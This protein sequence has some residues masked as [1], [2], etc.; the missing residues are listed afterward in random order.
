MHS[1]GYI[2]RDIKP[3]NIVVGNNHKIYLIDY[4]LAKKYENKLPPKT[5]RIIGNVRFASRQAHFGDS[6]KA[7][8]LESA[9]YVLNYLFM[10]YLPW[11]RVKEDIIKI[12]I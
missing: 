10:G 4:G 5:A 2:H 9:C 1:H 11:Q 6:S 3:N 12:E 8:D 7:S